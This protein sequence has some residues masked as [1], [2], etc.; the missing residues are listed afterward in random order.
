MKIK[1]LKEDVIEKIAAGEV[2]ERPASVL[3]ELIENALDA[4]ASRIEISFEGS[5]INLIEVSDNGIG[6]NSRE[7]ELAFKR[8]ATSKIRSVDDLSNITTLGFR[9]EALPSIGAVAK[10]TV[11]SSAKG[12]EEAHQYRVSGGKDSEVTAAARNAGTTVKAEDIF[13]NVPV[14]KKFLRSETTERKNIISV[15]ESLALARP[16]V[17]FRL[18]S[19]GRKILDLVPETV[20]ERFVN[21]SGKKLGG[22]IIDFKF[23]N[24]FIKL[25]GLLTGPELSFSNRNRIYTFMNRRPI[26]TPLTAHAVAQGYQS[27]I[28]QG[29]Y[30]ACVLNITVSP[31]LVDVNV[32]PTKKEVKFINQHGVH[33]IISKV[34]RSELEKTPSIINMEIPREKTAGSGVSR[35]SGY[36]TGTVPSFRKQTDYLK[37]IDLRKLTEFSFRGPEKDESNDR[38]D[39]PSGRILPRFQWKNKY[40]IAEDEDGILVI[41]QHTAW[42]RINYEKLKSQIKNRSVESQ[43]ALIPEIL[44]L[45]SSRAEVLSGKLELMKKYGI[46]IE[47]FGPNMF[48]ITAVT[49]IAGRAKSDREVIDMIENIISLFVEQEKVPALDDLN[50]TII[51]IIA[52]RSSIKAGDSMNDEE[53]RS[54]ISMLNKCAVPHRCPH[55]RPVIMRITESELDSKF[56]R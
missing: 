33:E 22:K 40:I 50:D 25:S 8:H 30:P 10:V 47:E 1:L 15:V 11:I 23:E 37:D 18:S 7:L 39:K 2:I 54:M 36:S 9:G 46:H 26:Y 17:A 13:F 19:G 34:I 56:S 12:S 3:K 28:P 44:E 53:V 16:D 32:H 31:E 14:R 35:G 21:I 4:K 55:G 51:K 49:S 29:R 43:G 52:C 27:Y 45:E 42:E 20:K 38:G 5:G 6:M 24:P 48:K 41:D